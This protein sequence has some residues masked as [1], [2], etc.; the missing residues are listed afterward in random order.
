MRGKKTAEM[1]I[2]TIPLYQSGT[3]LAKS[4]TLTVYT[5]TPNFICIRLLSPSR[6]KKKQFSAN[7]DIWGLLYPVSFTDEGRD[8]ARCRA[9]AH[10]A[11]AP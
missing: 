5:Y 10:S 1:S 8:D 9:A 11:A 6:D 2:L 4:S 7:F 3:N